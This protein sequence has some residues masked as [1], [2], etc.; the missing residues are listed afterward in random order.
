MR[1]EAN[2]QRRAI[3]A[4]CGIG[5]PTIGIAL[6]RVGIEPVVYEAYPRVT[7][8]TGAFL[9]V[10][11]NGLDALR[12]L[13]VDPAVLSE[14]FPTP[15][16]VMW[17]TTG[18]RLGEVANGTQ[19]EDGT[20]SMTIRRASL[21]R[22]LRGAAEQ[23]GVR[24]EHDKRLVDVKSYDGGVLATFE[25][26]TTATGDFLV[27]AD[28]IHSRT[29]RIVDPECPVPRY[30]GQISAGGIVRAGSFSPTPDAYHMIFGR[31]AFFGYS[32][33]PAGDAYWFANVGLASEP[34]G[35]SLREVGT[36][37][38]KAQLAEL[39]E[40]DAGPALG[41]IAATSEISIYPIHDL[42]KV[43]RWH[44]DGMVLVGDA[45]HATSPSAG[46]GASM[47]IEDAVV[48]AKCL[49]DEAEVDAAF[50]RYENARRSRVERVVKYSRQIGGSKVPGPV[51][52][53]FRDLFMPVALKAFA[54]KAAHAWLYDHRIDWNERV[55]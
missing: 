44:R 32:V 3:V 29:R 10:A 34:T 38:W 50:A 19:L 7:E 47:A 24:I 31:R 51:G 33:T 18:K 20:V 17:S 23:R 41:M 45:A 39:F 26:G 8:E 16:M 52:R 12:S 28:G 36:A 22:A 15:R 42:P 43:P 53:W 27:G 30:T 6:Q 48:L 40:G 55:A 46:Q 35:A 11:S 37:H 9:N 49:R 1:N 5:G 14:G 25:D 21:H 13:G 54:G 2:K 4:G